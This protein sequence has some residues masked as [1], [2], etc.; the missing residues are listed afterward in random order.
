MKIVD[1]IQAAKESYTLFAALI[2]ST[3]QHVNKL[4]KNSG[5]ETYAIDIKSAESIKLKAET[6][7]NGHVHQVKDILRG[8]IIVPNEELLLKTIMCI[9]HHCQESEG[10]M[11]IVRFKNLFRMNSVGTLVPTNLPTGYRHIIF[12]V[13]MSNGVIGGEA[14]L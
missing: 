14:L 8:Y 2:K 1:I 3:A 11:V 7:Y 10:S 9:K 6:K 13:K 5:T 12:N 4:D